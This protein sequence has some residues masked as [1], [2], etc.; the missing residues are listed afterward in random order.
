VVQKVSAVA[1]VAFM[2]G[3][4]SLVTVTETRT[5]PALSAYEQLLI[6]K[7]ADGVIP[8]AAF[9]D[10]DQRNR[11]MHELVTLSNRA[12]SDYEMG[13]YRSNAIVSTV[14]DVVIMAAGAGGALATGGV[15]QALAAVTAV[16]AGTRATVDKNFF[17]EQ[18]RIALIAKMTALRAAVLEEIQMSLDLPMNVYPMTAGLIDIQ[19]YV[20]AGTVLAALQAVVEDSG[21]E[22]QRT[23]H[24]MMGHR[25]NLGRNPPLR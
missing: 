13:I 4:C 15:S 9:H 3:G 11:V 23:R 12:Y 20:N 22:L 25:R 17:A 5:L 14:T 18:S 19:R 2:L 24:N 6:D 8:P 10:V 21:A 7:Y 1:F 16:V